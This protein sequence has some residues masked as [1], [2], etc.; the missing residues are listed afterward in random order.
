MYF[1]VI[2]GGFGGFV[3]DAPALGWR[4]AF[5]AAGLF[6]IAYALPLLVALRPA[7]RAATVISES[8]DPISAAKELASNASFLLLVLYFTFPALAGWAIRDWMPAILKERF[9]L[10]QGTAGVSATLYWTLAALVGVYFGGFLADR[11]SRHSARGRIYVSAAGMAMIVPA[12]FGV[13]HAPSLEFAVAFLVLFGLGWGFF[14]CNNMPILAQIVR[15]HLRATGYGVM[16][17]VSISCGGF[18]DLRF[19]QLKSAGV[20]VSYI[21]LGLSGFAVV[22]IMLVLLIRPKPDLVDKSNVTPV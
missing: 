10:G 19:G 4:F 16:N 14:D 5:D 13:G 8:P 18:A 9:E 2:L 3:A 22:S 6:G 1:G 11:A 21:F 12:L 15:P 17:L 20:P 7:P